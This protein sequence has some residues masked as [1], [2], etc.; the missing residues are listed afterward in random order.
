L[1]PLLL[2]LLLHHPT[3]QKANTTITNS[4]IRVLNQSINQS[5]NFK[6]FMLFRS[7][8]RRPTIQ[9]ATSK[10]SY[11]SGDGAIGTEAAAQQC[12][13]WNAREFGYPSNG[14]FTRIEHG[15]LYAM[16]RSPDIFPG[17]TVVQTIQEEDVVDF[18]VYLYARPERGSVGGAEPK[19]S[20]A[21]LSA[22]LAL[23]GEVWE[24]SSQVPQI[25]HKH[26]L[27]CVL[28]YAERQG[29]DRREE[30]QE[31]L[32]P[33]LKRAQ[34]AEKHA[35]LAIIVPLYVG[36]TAS[37]ITVSP[38]PLAVAYAAVNVGALR[39]SDDRFNERQNLHTMHSASERASNME[40]AG[41]LEESEDLDEG[42]EEEE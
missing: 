5:I 32:R 17:P 37:I 6:I 27:K 39:I 35:S 36:W 24:P 7:N 28:K 38:I 15:L 30:T 9:A 1:N 33:L 8:K 29:L 3:N 42:C 4:S 34:Q 25:L 13:D 14:F 40:Q 10:S 16:L 20:Y 31:L 18:S 21:Q 12:I 41:L 22:T 19:V 23:A 2:L 26:I 11:G